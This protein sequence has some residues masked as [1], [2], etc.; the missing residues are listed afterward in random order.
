MVIIG[1][2]SCR[3]LS[4][5][6]PVVTEQRT[7]N[8]FTGLSLRMPAT[9]YYTQGS[10]YRVELESNRNIVS[11]IETRLINDDLVLR[12]KHSTTQLGAGE[13]IVV[14][15]TAP[16][17]SKLEVDGSGRIQVLSS[18]SSSI[19]QL[20]LYGSGFID[21][22][23]VNGSTLQAMVSGSG[24]IK[25]SGGT[26]SN[27]SLEISGSAEMDMA[28]TISQHTTG[29]IAGSGN[30][31]VNVQQRLDVSISG[32]GRVRYLGNPVINSTISGSGAVARL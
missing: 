8:G 10:T 20:R 12:F 4:G 30:M 17:L 16:D 15:V 13:K 26:V 28:G 23:D 31:K 6:G 25:V 18:I 1:A 22:M 11:E 5:E 9:V 32:S 14:R 7:V 21:V 19:L 29:R 24:K 3:K 2:A 27:Q